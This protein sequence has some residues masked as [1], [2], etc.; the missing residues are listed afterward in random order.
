MKLIQILERNLPVIYKNTKNIRVMYRV[1][2]PPSSSASVMIVRNFTSKDYV[3]IADK[4]DVF[5]IYDET[6]I[7]WIEKGN[8]I[9]FPFYSSN[10]IYF[11]NDFIQRNISKQTIHKYQLKASGNNELST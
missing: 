2:K 9:E 10:L 11:S 7:L 6:K 1:R 3:V 4:G 5:G 8:W